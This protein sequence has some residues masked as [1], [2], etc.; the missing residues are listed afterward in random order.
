MI[1]YKLTVWFD[2]P[3][4]ENAYNIIETVEDRLFKLSFGMKNIDLEV[5]SGG[6]CYGPYYVAESSNLHALDRFKKKAASVLNRFHG[7]VITE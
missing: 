5:S 1:T 7:C 6:P 3:E 2:Y 4:R